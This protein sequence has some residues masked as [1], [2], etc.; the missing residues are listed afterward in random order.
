MISTKGRYALRIMIDLASNVNCASGD[1]IPLKD[2]ASR[3][4]ISLKYVERIVP[5]LTKSGFVQA[6]SGKN[7]GYRLAK[8]P[9]QITAGDI[10]RAS[11]GS[12]TPVK[13]AACGA[14]E[15]SKTDSCP[16]YPLWK[17]YD[18]ITNKYFDSVSLADLMQGGKAIQC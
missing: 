12:L 14:N 3:Q 18:N 15:C 8:A 11:E 6:A 16:T 4:D 13:C 7:G 1:Y 2:I 10:L 9:S 17:E 5:Q